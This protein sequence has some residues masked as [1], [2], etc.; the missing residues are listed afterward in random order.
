MRHYDRLHQPKVRIDQMRDLKNIIKADIQMNETLQYLREQE[1]K[2]GTSALNNELMSSF[3][4]YI[5]LIN[6]V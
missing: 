4:S 1:K 5:F 2:I 6:F 3:V